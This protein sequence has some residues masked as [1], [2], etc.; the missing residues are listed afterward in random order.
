MPSRIAPP[1]RETPSIALPEELA[2]RPEL[3]GV[4]LTS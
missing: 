3:S 1:S 4:G 2:G